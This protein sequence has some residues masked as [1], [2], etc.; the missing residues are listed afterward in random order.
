MLTRRIMIDPVLISLKL[1][2]VEDDRC[3]FERAFINCRGYELER[4]VGRRTVYNL[5][6]IKFM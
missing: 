5:S 2:P 4:G 3:P 6:E 1:K